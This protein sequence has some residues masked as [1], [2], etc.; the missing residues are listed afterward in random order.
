MS[1]PLEP[2]TAADLKAKLDAGASY[3]LLDVRE[4]AEFTGDLGHI[5][6]AELIPLGTLPA[7]L[8]KFAGEEREII[9][10]CASGA[11]AQRAADSLAKNGPKVR[12]LTGGTMAWKGAGFP[13]TR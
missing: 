4:P 3:R 12:V 5:E 10:I 11:R 9:S 6:G 1:K 2:I 8:G 13:T 7:N